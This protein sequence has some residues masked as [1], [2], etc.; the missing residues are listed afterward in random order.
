LAVRRERQV[1]SLAHQV[2]RL[3]A[4]ASRRERP[5]TPRHQ[6]RR[7]RPVM[8]QHLEVAAGP[9]WLPHLVAAGAAAAEF[10][11]PHEM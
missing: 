3:R 8:W 10:E 5:V 6:E 9:G 1:R 4:T 7:E 11:R 2:R